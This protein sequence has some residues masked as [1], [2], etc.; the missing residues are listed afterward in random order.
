MDLTEKVRAEIIAQYCQSR[1]Q[2]HVI[3]RKIGDSWIVQDTDYHFSDILI[4]G[5]D[6]IN[7]DPAKWIAINPELSKYIT[8]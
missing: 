5:I 4:I 7:K 3:L 8:S 2:T 6:T 1:K